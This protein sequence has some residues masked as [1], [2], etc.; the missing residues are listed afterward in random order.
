MTRSVLKAYGQAFL[1]GGGNIT[2]LINRHE[3]YGSGARLT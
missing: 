1:K 2:V 3:T